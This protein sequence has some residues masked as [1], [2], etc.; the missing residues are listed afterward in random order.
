M[1]KYNRDGFT[2]I[3]ILIAIAI[4]GIMAGI[5]IPAYQT[6]MKNARKTSANSTL[7]ILQ[8]SINQFNMIT[9]QYPRALKDLVRKPT[10]D[11]RVAKK[12]PG[13]LLKQKKVPDDP[14][15]N[16][17]QYKLTPGQKH[18]YELYSYGSDAGRS[19]PKDEWISAWD[20]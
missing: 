19:T 2:L 4:V 10:Y 7:K 1:Q 6:Y 13:P 20:E 5:S 12:W 3:E 11:E 14:W 17:Y 18:P 8:L 9:G 16:R 15:G